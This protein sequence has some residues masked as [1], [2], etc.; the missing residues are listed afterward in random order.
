MTKERTAF[1]AR[2]KELC[3]KMSSCDSS[4]KCC[5]IQC[6]EYCIDDWTRQNF[7]LYTVNKSDWTWC[8]EKHRSN[9]VADITKCGGNR[10]AVN[11]NPVDF[12]Q[13]HFHFLS[14]SEIDN[15]FIFFVNNNFV[16]LL[17]AK[18]YC[19][20]CIQILQLSVLWNARGSDLNR[21]VREKLSEHYW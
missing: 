1:A 17:Q 3:R 7:V 11:H 15:F 13:F 14:L 8:N 19:F 5:K 4:D 16:I 2:P 20:C 9:T 10:T 18:C 6:K 21:K 12:S